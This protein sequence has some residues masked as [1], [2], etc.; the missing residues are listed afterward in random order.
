MHITYSFPAM[1]DMVST[2]NEIV[3]RDLQVHISELDIRINPDGDL[4]APT[5]AREA[6]QRVRTRQVIEAFNALPSDKRFAVTCG[7]FGIRRAG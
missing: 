6:V 5:S 3:Q 4:S 2:M 7:E 1:S